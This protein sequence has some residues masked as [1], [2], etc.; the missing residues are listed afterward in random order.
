[1][2][3]FLHRQYDGQNKRSW[4]KNK[5]LEYPKAIPLWCASHQLNRV[6]VQSCTEQAIRNMI[7]TVDS[8]GITMYTLFDVFTQT[9]QLGSYIY[10]LQNFILFIDCEIF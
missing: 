9:D 6:I 1:M 5:N 10:P 8:V 3:Y 7:G 4:A 2:K